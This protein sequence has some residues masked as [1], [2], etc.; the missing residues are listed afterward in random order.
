MKKIKTALCL[1][2]FLLLSSFSTH[3]L[4]AQ[5]EQ[6][7]LT[8]D[9]S[10][11]DSSPTEQ[12]LCE[13]VNNKIA[14]HLDPSYLDKAAELEKKYPN[15]TIYT[16]LSVWYYKDGVKTTETQTLWQQ[17]DELV[18]GIYGRDQ[19]DSIVHADPNG[20]LY[21]TT[22]HYCSSDDSC[23]NFV[24]RWG[25]VF[26]TTEDSSLDFPAGMPKHVVLL[27]PAQKKDRQAWATIVPPLSGGWQYCGLLSPQEDVSKESK[28]IV[29]TPPATQ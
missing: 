3:Q 4:L 23:N 21:Y 11:D 15:A 1:I 29:Y 19:T 8:R 17:V 5:S 10:Y 9:N 28:V 6:P 26:S 13:Y 18:S 16:S 22:T 27:D 7:P 25:L 20:Q 24:R 2:A 14:G 12:E